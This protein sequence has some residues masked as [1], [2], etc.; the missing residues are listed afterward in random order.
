[1]GD[2][3]DSTW[4]FTKENK[5]PVLEFGLT[6]IDALLTYI[7]TQSTLLSAKCTIAFVKMAS[8]LSPKGLPSGLLSQSSSQDASWKLGLSNTLS[9]V[10]HS[11]KGR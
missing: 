8:A 3:Q 11:H 7:L 10:L 5:L 9:Q 2:A 6:I 4:C 1:M